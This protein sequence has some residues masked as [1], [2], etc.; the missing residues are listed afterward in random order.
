MPQI[1]LEYTLCQIQSGS[2]SLAVKTHRREGGNPILEVEVRP[3]DVVFRLMNLFDGDPEAVVGDPRTDHVDFYFLL[4]DL[5]ADRGTLPAAP[6]PPDLALRRRVVDPTGTERAGG[7]RIRMVAPISRY[8]IGEITLYSQRTPIFTAQA[9]E[10]ELFVDFE[11]TPASSRGYT[12]ETAE[13]HYG[14]DAEFAIVS[15]RA[16]QRDSCIIEM[17]HETYA[18]VLDEIL[19]L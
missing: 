1:N 15:D 8:A 17:T 6:V 5:R 11:T 9:D 7:R 2:V 14:V 16:N 13:V 19:T 12:T 4:E 18:T 10:A 3:N